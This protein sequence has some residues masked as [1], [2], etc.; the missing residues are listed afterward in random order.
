MHCG[1]LH[2]MHGLYKLYD[3][4][5]L[6]MY[7]FRTALINAC[8]WPLATVL[9]DWALTNLQAVIGPLR[10]PGICIDF[11]VFRA[12]SNSHGLDIRA[13]FLS[14]SSIIS[15]CCLI[16]AHFHV[17]FNRGLKKKF[18]PMHCSR[19]S[20]GTVC[21]GNLL[22]VDMAQPGELPFL[23]PSVHCKHP[24][25]STLPSACLCTHFTS[26]LL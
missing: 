5:L 6:N 21:T 12:Q 16:S 3:L 11:S 13:C 2:E 7:R 9:W 20:H 4:L 22:P 14:P 26:C 8:K 24:R 23:T 10:V 1:I 25:V 15:I 17:E 19:V 18:A